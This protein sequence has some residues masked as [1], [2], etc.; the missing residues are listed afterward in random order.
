VFGHP[1]V[2]ESSMLLRYEKSQ[3][4]KPVLGRQFWC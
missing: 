3:S 2:F 4:T 1:L